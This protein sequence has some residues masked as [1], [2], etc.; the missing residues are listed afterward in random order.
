M[1]WAGWFSEGSSM[2]D[3]VLPR[4]LP[5]YRGALDKEQVE[6]LQMLVA[7]VLLA[8]G[9]GAF[10][11]YLPRDHRIQFADFRRRKTSLD[12]RKAPQGYSTGKAVHEAVY[13]YF[14]RNRSEIT[15][16][17]EPL[18]ARVYGA[19]EESRQRDYW[20]NLSMRDPTIRA[21]IARD[22]PGIY[23]MFRYLE[24]RE[25]YG[26]PLINATLVVVNRPT[27]QARWCRFMVWYHRF[28]ELDAGPLAQMVGRIM[29]IDSQLF[30]VG[31]H[32]TRRAPY[33]HVTPLDLPAQPMGAIVS[34]MLHRGTKGQYMAARA[35]F[36]RVP[37]AMAGAIV[38]SNSDP[39]SPT[40]RYSRAVKAWDV[41]T[42][43]E[44]DFQEHF[45]LPAVDGAHVLSMIGNQPPLEGQ[46]PLT[47]IR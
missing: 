13:R 36:V 4:R 27:E 35:Y 19:Y 28:G 9:G 44:A 33:L 25:A 11:A 12:L 41:T 45:A 31:F 30:W 18:L 39:A 29:P 17:V 6:A 23:W 20:E 8:R 16:N 15:I 2:A 43:I 46:A 37:N 1:I 42:L 40:Q 3:E 5:P 7:H 10:D 47:R 21:A 14:S 26:Q 24:P 32:P 34:L 22:Y 38:D